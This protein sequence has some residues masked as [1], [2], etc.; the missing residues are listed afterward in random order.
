[1]DE[2]KGGG[3]GDRKDQERGEIEQKWGVA[4]HSGTGDIRLCQK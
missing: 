3:G 2:K 1:M 4:S